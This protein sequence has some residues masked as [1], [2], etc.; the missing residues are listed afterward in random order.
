MECW[1][2]S[3]ITQNPMAVTWLH[4]DRVMVMQHAILTDDDVRIVQ[5]AWKFSNRISYDMAPFPDNEQQLWV[6]EDMHF[7]RDHIC[8][9]LHDPV[10]LEVFAANHMAI[11]THGAPR[12]PRSGLAD[13]RHASRRREASICGAAAE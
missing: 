8:M 4:Y 12:R 5:H 1:T 7:P 9:S 3:I 6:L 13:D 10:P 2:P 11:V